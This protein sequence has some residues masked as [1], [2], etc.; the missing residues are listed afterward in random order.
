MIK[1]NVDSNYI[2]Q[3]CLDNLFKIN[4]TYTVF[5]Q[6]FEFLIL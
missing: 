4:N 3:V 1:K 6:I 2:I 5:L